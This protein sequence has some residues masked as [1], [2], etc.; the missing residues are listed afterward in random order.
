M[1][2]HMVVMTLVMATLLTGFVTRSLAEKNDPHPGSTGV[3]VTVTAIDSH[4]TMATLKAASGVLYQLS[5]DASWRVGDKLECDLMEPS[6]RP[7]VRLQH[8]RPWS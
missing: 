8:C 7:E 5:A 3:V 1:K 2:R 4:N 6:L